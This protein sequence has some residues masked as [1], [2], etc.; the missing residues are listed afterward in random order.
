MT[1]SLAS[2]PDLHRQAVRRVHS[3]FIFEFLVDT[4]KE[5]VVLK[6]SDSITVQER[7]L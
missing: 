4:L 1:C 5:E 7:S 3:T 6:P 2:N